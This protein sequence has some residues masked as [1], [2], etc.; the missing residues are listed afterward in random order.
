M[1]TTSHLSSWHA[2]VLQLPVCNEGVEGTRGHRVKVTAQQDG[3]GHTVILLC[4][5][6][7]LGQQKC[8]LSELDVAAPWVVQ[9]VSVDH[10]DVALRTQSPCRFQ[11]HNQSHIIPVQDRDPLAEKL[12]RMRGRQCEARLLKRNH[13]SI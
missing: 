11:H 9:Q 1:D 10:T 12:H 5:T 7:D 3:T 8:Q 13:A 6:T 4:N 2:C